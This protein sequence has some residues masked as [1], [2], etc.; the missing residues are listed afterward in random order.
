MKNKELAAKQINRF[1]Q[2]M[3]QQMKLEDS[4]AME[5]ADLYP[6][7]KMGKAYNADEI[8]KYGINTDNETQLYR[9]IQPHTSQAGWEPNTAT[10]LFKAIGFDKDGTAIWTQPIGAVD[11]YQTGD[12]VTHTGKMWISTVDDNVWEPGIYGW[13]ETT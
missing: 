13:E 9:V 10:S 2:I 4:I 8:V 7:W 1:F 5:I 11:A 6:D 12:V 3:S